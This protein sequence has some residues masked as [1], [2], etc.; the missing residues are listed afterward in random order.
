VLAQHDL[1]PPEPFVQPVVDHR[2]RAVPQLLRRLEHQQCGARPRLPAARQLGCGPEQAGDVDVVPAGVEHVDRV[3]LVV[4]S[5]DGAGV[6]QPGLLLHRQS[7][8]VAAK[9]DGPPIVAAAA[10]DGDE[11]AGR[12][13]LAIFER[14]PL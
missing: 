2:L 3:P 5:A 12:G 6:G 1:G 7:V 9:N 11:A 14:Q 8:H 13:A 4:D 10:K